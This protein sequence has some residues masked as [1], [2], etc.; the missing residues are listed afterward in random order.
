[1]GEE[2]ASDVALEAADGFGLGFAFVAAA[3]EVRA[4]VGVVGEAGDDDAPQGAV[5]LAVAGPAESM[6]L[7]LAALPVPGPRHRRG[8]RRIVR[9]GCGASSLRQRRGVRQRYRCR[10]RVVRSFLVRS[11]R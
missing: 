6:A 9:F 11:R 8:A 1:M 3:A 2:L 7:L 10:P 4:G 5:G